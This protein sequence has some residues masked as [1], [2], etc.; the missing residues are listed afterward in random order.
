MNPKELVAGVKLDEQIA[1]EN[2]LEGIDLAA[3]YE[4]TQE[5]I[6]ARLAEKQDKSF[7]VEVS[8]DL[9][10]TDPVVL[11]EIESM[12]T[13]D[14]FYVQEYH[15]DSAKMSR[16]YIDDKPAPQAKQRL[17]DPIP[18]YSSTFVAYTIIVTGILIML[19]AA[20]YFPVLLS[21]AMGS[22]LVHYH[23]MSSRTFPQSP[24]SGHNAPL[25]YQEAVLKRLDRDLKEAPEESTA[26]YE[27]VIQKF[28]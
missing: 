27:G 26:Y 2:K 20:V 28:M 19:P 10:T 11:K 21:A 14:G 7:P 3:I 15:G 25:K 24:T 13:A 17:T 12:L 16:L 5:H 22:I 18:L 9:I 4:K 8:I 6:K 23:E 1:L